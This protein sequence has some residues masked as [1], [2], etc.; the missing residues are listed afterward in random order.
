M[1]SR[2]L[3]A[4]RKHIDAWP[5]PFGTRGDLHGVFRRSGD[6][7]SCAAPAAICDN[8]RA[9]EPWVSAGNR[10]RTA[11]LMRRRSAEVGKSDNAVSPPT[12]NAATVIEKLASP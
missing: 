10:H 4:S 2:F 12:P 11:A 5:V 9:P 6:C 1:T 8:D 7:P 3:R